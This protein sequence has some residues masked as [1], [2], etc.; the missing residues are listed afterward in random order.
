MADKRAF[1]IEFGGDFDADGVQKKLY[2]A[3][4][5]A[6]SD[7][8]NDAIK[9]AKWPSLGS[10]R[11]K[12]AG[13]K[14]APKRKPQP[15]KPQEPA[16]GPGGGALE[17]EKVSEAAVGKAYNPGAD[18]FD[19]N[20]Y[21][22]SPAF[23]SSLQEAGADASAVLAKLDERNRTRNRVQEL[24][25]QKSA[26]KAAGQWR[27]LSL[28]SRSG[29]N[30]ALRSARLSKA[31][32]ELPVKFRGFAQKAAVGA[33]KAFLGLVQKAGS[34]FLSAVS[35]AISNISSM[36]TMDASTSL[37]T[38]SAARQQM[39][40]FG[41]TGSQNYAMTGAMSYLG[42]SSVEDL[43]WMNGAQRSA[44][45]ELTEMLQEQYDRLESSGVLED[46]QAIQLD[47]VKLKLQ[48][49]DSVYKFI[50]ENKDT[51][52]QFMQ[53]VMAGMRA[54]LSMSGGFMDFMTTLLPP[55]GESAS[56]SVSTSVSNQQRYADI[57][58]NYYGNGSKSE[59]DDFAK[60]IYGAMI[61]AFGE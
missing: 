37:F 4:F 41:L 11:R 3:G 44:Y 33:G 49:Q 1:E 46:I 58:V 50:S 13:K 55:Y 6:F 23:T 16:G 51:I 25:T 14:A 39:L 52:E 36:A 35:K 38:N 27:K 53:L 7:A 18:A 59:A 40:K 12:A 26:L 2:K 57:S 9:N 54:L 5:A 19:R 10:G 29:I 43:M 22:Q 30:A 24:E 42:M 21:L 60:N 28:G 15:R 17:G 48:F 31:K 8:L 32:D 20:A 56:S 45:T 47:F 61:K 34:A